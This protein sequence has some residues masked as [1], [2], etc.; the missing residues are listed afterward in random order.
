[1]TPDELRAAALAHEPPTDLDPFLGALWIE[2]RGVEMQRTRSPRT[3]TAAR[4][5]GFM[6]TC[7]AE[8]A[9]SETQLTGVVVPR[10]RK[11]RENSRMSGDR[12]PARCLNARELGVGERRLGEAQGPA[13]L[14]K[15]D[16]I[17]GDFRELRL[18]AGR[19]HRGPAWLAFEP[20][21]SGP[22]ANSGTPRRSS[23]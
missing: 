11:G 3:T 7:I 20:G 10:V 12:L 1:M 5:H 19:F 14:D 23:A 9:T 6:L 15:S 16:F 21:F 22:F 13:G 2:A 17:D 8:R 4:E 18:A